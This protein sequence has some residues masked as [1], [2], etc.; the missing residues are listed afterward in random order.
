MRYEEYVRTQIEKYKKVGFIQS[1]K[2][3]ELDLY[4]DQAETLLFNQLSELDGKM[5]EKLVSRTAIS[6]YVKNGMIAKPDGKRYS[7]DHMEMIA[8]VYYLR[9]LFK[10]EEVIHLMKPLVENYNS[11]YEDKIDPSV[12]YETARKVNNKTFGNFA[13]MVDSDITDIKK[14]LEETDIADDERMEILTFIL[15]LCMKANM[16]KYLA[17]ML[18]E[19]YF[20]APDMEKPSKI[21]NERIKK[22][23]MDE[24]E[25]A[26]SESETEAAEPELDT[27]AEI[28]QEA[29][30]ET[31]PETELEPELEAEAETEQTGE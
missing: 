22:R 8:I 19:T 12:I 1:E 20:K 16:E 5:P 31:E 30:P 21:K 9:G 24:G 25:K 28:E 23:N 18:M 17:S 7:K 15:T 4:V 26:E 6:N 29:E 3:P 13:K 27:E 11:K 2:L 14:S 10:I